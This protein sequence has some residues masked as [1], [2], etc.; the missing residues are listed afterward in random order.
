MVYSELKEEFSN[1][2]DIF[3]SKTNIA[4]FPLFSP[5]TLSVKMYSTTA[6]DTKLVEGLEYIY[7]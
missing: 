5:Y 6:F 2:D 3:N 7:P 4:A 1:H